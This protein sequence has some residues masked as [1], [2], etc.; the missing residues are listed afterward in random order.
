MG[1]INLEKSARI[2]AEL[3]QDKTREEDWIKRQGVYF[4]IVSRERDRPITPGEVK[5]E[6][7]GGNGHGG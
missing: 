7:C 2:E 3:P 6:L 4:R 5:K 1:E